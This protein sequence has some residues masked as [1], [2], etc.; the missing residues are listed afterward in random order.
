MDVYEQII[1]WWLHHYHIPSSSVYM[2]DKMTAIHL[3]DAADK[4]GELMDQ[5]YHLV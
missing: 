5:H 4:L 2:I 3:Q 1:Y